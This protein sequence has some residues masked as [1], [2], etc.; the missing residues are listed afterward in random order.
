MNQHVFIVI[1][2]ASVRLGLVILYLSVNASD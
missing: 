2:I 1:P